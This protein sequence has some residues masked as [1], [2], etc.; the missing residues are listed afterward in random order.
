MDDPRTRD[1]L[2][3]EIDDLRR[4]LARRRSTP[5]DS[6][7][8]RLILDA[9]PALVSYV[10]AGET[11]CLVNRHYEE[12]FGRPRREILGLTLREFLG[13]AAYEILRPHVRAALAGEHVEYTTAIDYP[14]GRRHIRAT[15]TPHLA[16]DGA[17]LGYVSLVLDVSSAQRD[18]EG[19]RFL[20]QASQAL[21]T[22]LDFATTLQTVTSLAVPRLGEWCSVY[23]VRQG[24][25]DRTIDLV[26]VSHVEPARAA[27][28]RE[29]HRRWPPDRD[30]A[31]GLTR[32]LRDG[33]TRLV[34]RVDPDNYRRLARDDEH[35]AALRRL[36]ATSWIITP[37]VSHEHVFGAIS[38]GLTDPERQFDPADVALLEELARRAAA[39]LENARLFAAAQRER[40]R[41]EEANQAKDLF[42]S[43]LSH[44]LRTPLTAVL[45]WTRLLRTPGLS[46]ERREH[47]LDTID[48]NARAQVAIVEDILDIGRIVTG[49]LRLDLR[50]LD[51]IP[52]LAS[53]VESVRPS[54]DARGVALLVAHDL[55]GAPAVPVVRGDPDRLQQVL[56]NL[57][58]NALKFTPR[59]G[60]VRVALSAD[61]RELALA[62]H[63]TGEG[64]APEFLP[65]VFDRFRQA[66]ASTTRAHG[67]L[68]LGLAIVRHL[69]E[70]HGG[71][72]EA[73]SDGPGRGSRFVVRLP[74]LPADGPAR[75]REPRPR[76]E[77][78]TDAPLLARPPDLAGLRVLV[79]DDEPDTRDLVVGM[80]G[81]CRAQVTAVASVGEALAH[82]EQQR[83]DII[84]SDI[85]MP[86]ADGY[87]LIREL[88]ARPLD[89]GGRTP[90]VALTA[91]ARAEDRTRALLAGFDRHLAKPI[92]PAD[93]LLTLADLCGRQRPP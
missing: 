75:A 25:P 58:T 87:A 33:K 52:L 42:L 36:G 46:D 90:T 47:G 11:Y 22:S 6:E 67:G 4:Q 71:S 20:A 27:E 56:W 45:G 44:E 40:A 93:L 21:G 51:F 17:V 48:R 82:I 26:A 34:P 3:A 49:K 50:P 10:D 79:V 59:G 83:F 8:L 57:L 18:R 37:L 54:A 19:L 53:T 1:E 80:L 86:H 55:A 24:D 72:V 92:E 41:A 14:N 85:A 16:A 62:V 43:N 32:L 66:D 28:I 64:I 77:P 74:L 31:F 84:V 89:R 76:G 88:R 13:E 61:E 73:H 2:L 30:S 91:Y 5:G 12:W 78:P 70:L 7:E 68:G 65:H 81:P 60:S 29:V 69:V 39:A 23:L 63:D 35:A 15:Y 9:V 38:L